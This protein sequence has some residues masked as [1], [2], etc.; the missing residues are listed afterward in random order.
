MV[1]DR[2][3]PR[4]EPMVVAAICT[5]RLRPCGCAD[6][7]SQKEVRSW[8]TR[9][10]SPRAERQRKEW[11]RSS[12]WRADHALWHDKASFALC[13]LALA[14]S[15]RGYASDFRLLEKIKKHRHPFRA[16]LRCGGPLRVWW[17]CFETSARRFDLKMAGSYDYRLVILSVLI[18]ICTAYSAL[19][20]AGRTTAA[21]GKWRAA[22]L[23]GGAVAMG[24]GIWSM[25]YVGMLAF[26]LP[27]QVLYDW[28]TVL[29]SLIAAIV[30][31][32]VALFVT[33][34]SQMTRSGVVVGSVIMGS[35]ISTMHYTGM[36]AM[37]L[38]AMC[39]YDLSLVTLS[40]ILAI[41]ISLVALCLTFQFRGDVPR[42]PWLKSGTALI[43]GSA[44][45]VMHYTGM[46][47]AHFTLS[48]LIPDTAHAVSTSTL[49][50]TG[51]SITTV[52]ISAVAVLTSTLDR[53]FAA[54]R[55]SLSESEQ[56]YQLLVDG[57]KDYAIVML[58][59]DGRVGSWNSGAERIEGYAAEEILGQPF[60][61]FF[62]PE[63]RNE[64][65]PAELLECASKVGRVED[66]GWRV[67]K[68]GS[69]FWAD[70]VITALRDNVGHLQGF[71]KMLR[72]ATERK[73]A[74]EGLRLLSARLLQLRDE[75]RRHIARELHD[76]AGQIIAALNMKLAPI[77]KNGKSKPEIDNIIRESLELLQQ[78]STEVRTISHLLHPP[79]LD[80][81]G[82]SSALRL[83]VEG[84]SER[85]NI[86]VEL[87]IPNDFGRLSRELE[88]AIFRVVQESLTNI[89][90]HS[91]SETARIKIWLEGN[92]VRVEVEDDGK[93]IAAGKHLESGP[94]AKVGVGLRGMYER[95]RQLGGTL[96]ICAGPSGRG[97]RLSICVPFERPHAE[98]SQDQS[99]ERFMTDPSD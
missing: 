65:K 6:I 62:P 26:S 36:A 17:E 83:Y 57:V 35:G 95:I 70:V 85:S 20:L 53:R 40:V 54:Q 71:S 42:S 39:D 22:W 15:N 61:G 23:T 82:L 79:L 87:D 52:V 97:T 81:V 78:L 1:W 27:I 10:G 92:D 98:T 58:T 73:R 14:S 64:N 47:A 8:R 41:S 13:S 76:S 30:A 2:E 16:E 69:R 74:E 55:R 43:M 67:R 4:T 7:C 93:G 9:R 48:T 18:A 63:D 32:G 46:A 88:T 31:S 25:H 56:R 49:G 5:R 37:R 90:R 96:E 38:P 75:E 59:P 66:Q 68:D 51:V 91:G 11:D 80:E 60:S 19:E 21:S 84:F 72:D 34:R 50:F 45:P 77:V 33:S 99:L 89:H 24:F 3:G 29:L 94:T 28:P 44:I 12:I 86:R